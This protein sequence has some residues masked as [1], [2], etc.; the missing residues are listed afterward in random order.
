MEG[1]AGS[2]RPLLREIRDA[3]WGRAV[4]SSTDARGSGNFS[5]ASFNPCPRKGIRRGPWSR[6]AP[7]HLAGELL[8]TAS[9][10]G[11]RVPAVRVRAP[12]AGKASWSACHGLV[13]LL[14]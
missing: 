1:P 11:K 8:L 4:H 14:L 13:L 2:V 7:S 5:P 3:E 10:A 9:A 6:A 12:T